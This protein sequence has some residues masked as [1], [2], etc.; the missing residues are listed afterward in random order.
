[1]PKFSIIIP[2]YNAE[3]YLEESINSVL[4]QSYKDF[5]L[6]LVNDGS[7]DNSKMICENYASLDNRVKVINCE[8]NGS[9]IARNKGIELAIGEYCYFVDSDD[10]LMPDALDIMNQEVNDLNADL[11][12]FGFIL[13]RRNMP[14]EIKKDRMNTCIEGNTIRNYYELYMQEGKTYIQGPPW[15]KLFK[16]KNIKENNIL[17]PSLRRNQDEVFIV[18]YM[19]TVNSVKFS[20]KLIYKHYM[21][22][23]QEEWNKFPKNYF[24]IRTSVYKEFKEN[25]IKWNSENIKV[26]ILID[27]MY[28]YSIIR[29]FE[30]MFNPKWE[31]NKKARKDYIKSISNNNEVKNSI[32]FLLENKKKV[33]EVIKQVNISDHKINFIFIEMKLIQKQ[34]INIIY[35]IS[36]L[37]VN[38]RELYRK[39]Q[40]R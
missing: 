5:E 18:R 13:K 17:Y 28:I 1:M 39:I 14:K 12:V 2:V 35:I 16:T 7:K 11:Y 34:K 15:N 6:I 29:C 31:M 25:I 4:N 27:F 20:D 33:K 40:Y 30:Y 32:K 19:N 36:K 23:L 10:I 3:E 26:K 21:N 24:E 8:N 9:G 22:D 37:M 38:I